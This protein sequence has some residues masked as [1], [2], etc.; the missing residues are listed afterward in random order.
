LGSSGFVYC[1]ALFVDIC[2]GQLDREI[3]KAIFLPATGERSCKSP[4]IRF[5]ISLTNT[6]FVDIP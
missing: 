5:S 6:L 4:F 3:E 1:H 2:I